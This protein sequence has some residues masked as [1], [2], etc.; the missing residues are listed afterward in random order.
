MSETET[1][2]F[3]KLASAL[4]QAS[5]KGDAQA[6]NEAADDLEVIAL[7]GAPRIAAQAQRLADTARHATGG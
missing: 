6:I 5:E 3:W 2:Y 7:H 1:R 4:R